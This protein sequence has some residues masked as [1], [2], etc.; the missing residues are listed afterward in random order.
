MR[1]GH[2]I[3]HEETVRMIRPPSELRRKAIDS[4]ITEASEKKAKPSQESNSSSQES[5]EIPKSSESN[6]ADS[7]EEQNTTIESEPDEPELQI[8]DDEIQE[9][10]LDEDDLEPEIPQETPRKKTNKERTEL[11]QLRTGSIVRVKVLPGNFQEVSNKKCS[12]CHLIL[13]SRVSMKVTSSFQRILSQKS[14]SNT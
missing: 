14:F 7:V 5:I 4:L 6:K 8:D 13:S 3:E 10:P 1:E 2:G 11:I 9:L 12:H